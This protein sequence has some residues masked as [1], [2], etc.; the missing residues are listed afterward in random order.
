MISY[1]LSLLF[2]PLLS[3]AVTLL[4]LRNKGNLASLLSVS[5]A[6]GILVLAMIVIF[7]SGEDLL[8]WDTTW[9]FDGGIGSTLRFFGRFVRSL[10]II[11]RSLHRL[12][13]SC[14]QPRLHGK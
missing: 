11:H 13:D 12:F 14:I 10:A 8:S 7:A 5:T 4:F 6:G 1:V 9:F 3:A 2:L